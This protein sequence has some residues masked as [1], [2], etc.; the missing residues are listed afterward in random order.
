MEHQMPIDEAIKVE[1]EARRDSIIRELAEIDD[2]LDAY[3][4]ELRE[5]MQH[6]EYDTQRDNYLA[7][8]GL[9]QETSDGI[10]L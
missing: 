2:W 1:K 8:E 5:D 6:D 7:N 4:A 9:A 3:Y 10:S